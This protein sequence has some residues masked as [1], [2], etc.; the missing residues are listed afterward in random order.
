MSD[1]IFKEIGVIPQYDETGQLSAALPETFNPHFVNTQ[2]NFDAL[3]PIVQDVLAAR[4]DSGS[5]ADKL[6]GVD[7]AIGN[8]ATS[9]AVAVSNAVRRAWSRSDEGYAV[10]E[11]SPNMT[12]IEFESIAVTRTVSGDDSID[13]EST[14]TLK[15]GNTYVLS[16]DGGQESITVAE[17]LNGTRF[18]ATV[19]MTRTLAA[20]TIGQ[21]D[22]TI[23]PGYAIAPAGGIYYSSAMSVL[24]YYGDGRLDIRRDNGDGK[25]DVQVRASGGEW[26]A[27]KLLETVEEVVGTRNEFYQLPVGGIVELKIQADA[28]TRVEYLM[29][30]TSPEAG[31]AYPVAQPTNLTPAQGAVSVVDPVTFTGTAP[32][33][34]YGIGIASVTV[35]I[36][37]DI[38]MQNIIYTG[39]DNN[40]SGELAHTAPG[41][42]LEVDKNYF[43]WFFYTDEDG[44]TSPTSKATGFST[45]AIFQY[46]VPPLVI[47]PAN[48]STDV[49]AP[50]TITLSDFASFGAEDTL[51]GLRIEASN[52]LDFSTIL[53]D[54]GE[55]APGMDI[56]ITEA[57]GLVVSSDLYIRPYHK[58]TNLGWSAAGPVC[59]VRMADVF[60]PWNGWSG[61]ADGPWT[62]VSHDTAY[63]AS[64]AAVIVDSKTA[65]A[66]SAN[67]SYLNFYEINRTSDDA[68]TITS[69]NV[70]N[71]ATAKTVYFN[72]RTTLVRPSELEVVFFYEA[73]ALL[74]CVHLRRNNTSSAFT[75]GVPYSLTSTGASYAVFSKVLD[76]NNVLVTATSGGTPYPWNTIVYQMKR[77]DSSNNFAPSVVINKQGTG[78]DSLGNFNTHL[79]DTLSA[80]ESVLVGYRSSDENYSCTI[81][82]FD[83]TNV[84]VEQDF[85]FNDPYYTNPTEVYHKI[86]ETEGKVSFASPYLTFSGFLFEK[87]AGAWGITPLRPTTSAHP[88]GREAM[89]GGHL[90]EDYCVAITSEGPEGNPTTF[91]K[92]IADETDV[93]TEDIL[94]VNDSMYVTFSNILPWS[95]GTAL[96]TANINNNTP[97]IRAK[98]LVGG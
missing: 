46:V 71:I 85:T 32:R 87:V 70:A 84:T 62:G 12:L 15:V 72:P 11:F 78:S 73:N 48:N 96:Y 19:N 49:M 90:S 13:V 16:Y 2:E 10:E 23:Y 67:G 18:K 53:F 76:E 79:L 91:T 43:W 40:P 47:S 52:S 68:N 6:A 74:Y 59:K 3:E 50:L 31:R 80:N 51:A 88:V 27:A 98:V 17:I 20:G 60:D 54:S 92:L 64:H 25:L 7:T 69:N 42:T 66:V 37:T 36:A 8:L 75:A 82:Y 41:G 21:T 14:A 5:L 58:G 34:L 22:W 33:S 35:Q 28:K 38:N 77:V 26:Q 29:V 95:D 30:Y 4:G 56:V 63:N 9:D 55:V 61:L 44:N 65:I 93:L 1:N 89:R 97:G 45:A 39:T 94:V 57:D 86:S 83:G 24:R 81:F